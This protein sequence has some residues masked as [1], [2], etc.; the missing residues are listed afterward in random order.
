[1]SNVKRVVL[2]FG[3]VGMALLCV[4]CPP[5]LHIM[6]YNNTGTN[7]SVHVAETTYSL[8]T[9]SSTRVSPE[10]SPWLTISDGGKTLKYDISKFGLPSEYFKPVWNGRL[11]QFQIQPDWRIYILKPDVVMPLQEMPSQPPG[12]PLIP[13]TDMK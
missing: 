11:V 9:G 6:L 8:S 13:T 10:T 12:F 1:M 2:S 4:A 3:L 7:I 5:V